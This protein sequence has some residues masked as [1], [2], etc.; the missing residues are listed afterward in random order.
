MPAFLKK[1]DPLILLIIAAVVVAIIAPAQGEFARVFKVLTNLAI[2]LL[3]YLYGAR[4]SPHEALAG[5]KNWRLHL[6]IAALTFVAY[7]FI[8]LLLRPVSALI[9]HELY[10]GIL[11]LTLVPSTVNSSVT[12]T[13]IAKGNVAG[14]I[15][16]ASMS[17]LVG[18]V[19]TPLL[20]AVCMGGEETADGGIHIDASVIG[21]IALLLLLPF[22]L[23]QLTRRWVKDF[24]ANKG[25]KIV[26]RG[27]ITMVVYSA[28]SSGV[29]AGI[30]SEIGVGELAFLVVFAITLVAVMLWLTRMISTN[31]GFSR[32]DVIATQFCGSKKSLATGV[33]MASVIFGTGGTL[34]LIILPLMIYHQVQLMMCSALA[35]RYATCSATGADAGH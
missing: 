32:G 23:G 25:T 18:V 5:L 9:P 33:P 3:F 29:A 20:I 6:T 4:L 28:F 21:E 8:G 19:L 31:L 12:F 14:A 16:A 2:A 26:D 1:I 35:S 11:F 24:A 17:N 27:S 34:G 22:A 10:L 7:P 15:V 13:S 30:W